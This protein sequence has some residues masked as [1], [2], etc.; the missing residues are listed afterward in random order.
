MKLGRL[1]KITDLREVW[2]TEAQYFTPWLAGEE[3]L[4]L[5]GDTIND[6]QRIPTG[7]HR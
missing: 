2:K 4:A 7:D 5:L 6:I 3:N 1:E